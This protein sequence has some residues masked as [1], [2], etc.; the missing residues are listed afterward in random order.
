LFTIG[1]AMKVDVGVAERT[2]SDGVATHANRR[3]RTD[4]IEDL[5][6]HAF[7]DLGSEVTNVERS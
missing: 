5:K 6:E 1:D 2:T 4:L 3:H 7:G